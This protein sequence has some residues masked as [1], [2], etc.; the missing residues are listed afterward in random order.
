MKLVLN[1]PDETFRLLQEKS[2][3]EGRSLESLILLAAEHLVS[4]LSSSVRVRLPLVPS[5]RPG[6]LRLD[7]VRIYAVIELP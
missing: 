2:A 3:Q 6:S 4:R 1:I 5:K 7:N